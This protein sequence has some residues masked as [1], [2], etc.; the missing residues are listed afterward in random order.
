META[1]IIRYINFAIILMSFYSLIILALISLR[2]RRLSITYTSIW[3]LLILFIPFLGAI[4]LW[5]VNP[6]D[7]AVDKGTVGII[8]K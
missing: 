4:A 6:Q 3:A 1:M 5:I 7:E 2:N 8:N